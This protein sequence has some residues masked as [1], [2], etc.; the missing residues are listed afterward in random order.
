MTND[1]KKLPDEA[2]DAVSGGLDRFMGLGSEAAAQKAADWVNNLAK[3]NLA[4]NN[5]TT[6]LNPE[7]LKP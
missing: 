6:T 7:D 5:N 3:E 1:E 4:A 2:L